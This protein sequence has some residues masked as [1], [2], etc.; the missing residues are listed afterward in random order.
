MPFY[1]GGGGGA[2]R[3]LPQSTH[4]Q[5]ARTCAAHILTAAHVV[6]ARRHEDAGT[7]LAASRTTLAA[8]SARSDVASLPSD[9][10]Q[11]RE[12]HC[13][14][15]HYSSQPS[16]LRRAAAAPRPRSS[17]VGSPA[18]SCRASGAA[19][20]RRAGKTGAYVTGQPRCSASLASLKENP[21]MSPLDLIVAQAA[22]LPQRCSF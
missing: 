14:L 4:K 6:N 9:A 18:R 5:R 13:R 20:T 12:V 7:E 21:S 15:Q 11:V 8:K 17:S 3:A 2:N 1:G 19:A 16:A 22:L 10:G